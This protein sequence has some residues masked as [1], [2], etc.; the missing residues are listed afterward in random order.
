M[1]PMLGPLEMEVMERVWA[2]PGPVSVREVVGELNEKRTDRLAY[3]TVMTVM[4][5]LAEKGALTRVREG[6]GYRYEPVADDV[7][8]LAVR[9]VLREFGDAALAHF[10]DEARADPKTLKRLQKLLAED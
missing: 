9:G 6:R 7:A 3:T 4:T 10:V 5:R 2:A 1:A 8:G